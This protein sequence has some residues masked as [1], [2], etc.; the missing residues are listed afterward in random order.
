MEKGTSKKSKTKGNPKKD[1][2]NQNKLPNRTYRNQN[3]CS[4]WLSR[5]LVITTIFKYFEKCS[6][7]NSKLDHSWQKKPFC[8]TVFKAA[9]FTSSVKCLSPGVRTSNPSCRFMFTS[10]LE[11]MFYLN[12]HMNHKHPIC[13]DDCIQFLLADLQ[14]PKQCFTKSMWHCHTSFRNMARSICDNSRA[15]SPGSFFP[16]TCNHRSVSFNL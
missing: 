14:L 16:P 10:I 8:F 1:C 5:R 11:Q 3:Q 4:S 13:L 7:I 9:K 2:R 15:Y 6:G 12:A